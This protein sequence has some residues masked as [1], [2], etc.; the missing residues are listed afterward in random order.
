MIALPAVLPIALTLGALPLGILSPF[1]LRTAT[2]TRL[3]AATLPFA[4]PE[5]ER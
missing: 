3:T 4:T 1:I 2:V 5:Q